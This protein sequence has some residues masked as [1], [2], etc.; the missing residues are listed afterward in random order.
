VSCGCQSGQY[1]ALVA[2]EP[3]GYQAAP[4]DA[5]VKVFLE[6]AVNDDGV[7]L[8]PQGARHA[9]R[10]YV[11]RNGGGSVRQTDPDGR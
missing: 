7:P 1:G 8:Y 11:A 2:S 6:G 3:V 4:K 9:A 5:E 10:M